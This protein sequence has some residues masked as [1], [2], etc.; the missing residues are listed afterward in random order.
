VIMNAQE[1]RVRLI[2]ANLVR[3]SLGLKPRNLFSFLQ[4]G[5]T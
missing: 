4:K 2:E 3:E 5:R 1:K